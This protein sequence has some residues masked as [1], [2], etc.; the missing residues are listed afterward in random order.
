MY[1]LVKWKGYPMSDNSWEP[2]KN[3]NA[4]E[5]I[6][7]FKRGFRPKKAKGRKVFIRAG[8]M[9]YFDSS[10]SH[11]YHNTLLLFKEMSS[12]SATS[13]HVPSTSP[14]RASSLPPSSAPS[15]SPSPE[16]EVPTDYKYISA[17]H[18]GVCHL[19]LQYNH[20]KWHQGLFDSYTCQCGRTASKPSPPDNTPEEGLTPQLAC[21]TLPMPMDDNDNEDSE[22]NYD[23]P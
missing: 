15:T 10:P 14:V 9:T 18:C 8:H 22:V 6:A 11:L 19:P 5:L 23:D 13:L 20:I 4:D 17:K 12:E 7:K 2:E 3:L 1:Y 16:L 21:C